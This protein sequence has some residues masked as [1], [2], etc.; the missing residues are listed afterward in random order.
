VTAEHLRGNV[1]E[2][3]AAGE[4][5]FTLDAESLGAQMRALLVALGALPRA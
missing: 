4:T 3:V 5:A 1:V 2:E